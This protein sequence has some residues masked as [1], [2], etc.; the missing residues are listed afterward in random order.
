[1]SFMVEISIGTF[2]SPP[3]L[4]RDALRN[5]ATE[6]AAVE[7]LDVR[8]ELVDHRVA[9][10]DRLGLE[11]ARARG[12]IQ[13]AQLHPFRVAVGHLRVDLKQRVEVVADVDRRL[14]LP[15][16]G[17]RAEVVAAITTDD[18]LP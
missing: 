17:R 10:W 13:L 11:L 5:L 7:A 4:R 3:G 6:P 18:Q 2:L 16:A 8:Q 1:M 14:H 12:A 15:V 9:G